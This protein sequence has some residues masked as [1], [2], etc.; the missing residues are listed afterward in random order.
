MISEAIAP[1]AE[2]VSSERLADRT[3]ITLQ[4]HDLELV[5]REL[6]ADLN[7]NGQVLETGLTPIPIYIHEAHLK[8]SFQFK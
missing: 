7:E 3:L 5:E 4:C 1:G 2:A 8:A 6:D